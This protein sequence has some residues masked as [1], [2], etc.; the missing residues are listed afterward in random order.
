MR[1]PLRLEYFPFS[2]S[3]TFAVEL[4]G[5]S[6]EC[7]RVRLLLFLTK[8]CSPH[9]IR[10]KKKRKEPADCVDFGEKQLGQQQMTSRA[11]REKLSGVAGLVVVVVVVPGHW[12]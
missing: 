6:F 4:I 1:L 12:I 3:K 11:G 5:N 8:K 9:W 7:V 2:I 10:N